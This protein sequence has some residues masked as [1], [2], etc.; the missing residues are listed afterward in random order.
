[1][2]SL[3]TAIILAAGGSTRFEPF[4]RDHHKSM[5][6]VGGK[7][8]IHYTLQSL[9]NAGIKTA[10]IVKSP[11]DRAISTLP[12]T[13]G[14]MK[15]RFVNQEKPLGQADAILSAK[16]YFTRQTLVLNAQQINI[17]DHLK[18]LRAL[19]Q[20][21]CY[22][23]STATDDPHKYGLLR[24]VGNRVT[25]V[26]EKP[27]SFQDLSN[28]RIV[29]IYLLT[30]EFIDFMAANPKEEYQL[31]RDLSA[32]SQKSKIYSIPTNSPTVSL[33][34]AWD[35]L[36]IS[37]ML[38]GLLKNQVSKKSFISPHAV[39]IG[40]VTISP[41]AQIFEHTVIEGPC[42][43]G[44]N[45]LV[46]R[47]TEVRPY[48]FLEEG[49]VLQRRVEINKSLFGKNSRIHAG[50]L[51]DSVIGEQVKVAAGFISANRRLDRGV[52]YTK[53]KGVAV[54]T[55]LTSLGCLVGD[56]ARFGIHTGTNPGRIIPSNVTINPGK[57]I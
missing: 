37:R 54:N 26:I 4:V 31:E 15:I 11:S 22:L 6:T 24:L 23:L 18:K 29:G 52:I 44:K 5:F 33:K 7:P 17:N 53:V 34:Y 36:H 35:L 47:F 39:I 14:R 8:I 10:V 45:A 20:N 42:Y 55:G 30:P 27:G 43:I 32:F 16:K 48:T 46:G 40:P 41:G 57:V 38:A 56:N 50:F 25:A 28:K 12:T 1:M 49:S 13:L 2:D 21:A 19:D 3:D 51:G 9:K